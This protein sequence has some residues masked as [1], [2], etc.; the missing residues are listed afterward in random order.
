[1]F[2]EYDFDILK[3]VVSGSPIERDFSIENETFMTDPLGQYA[4]TALSVDY[5]RLALCLAQKMCSVITESKSFP[6]NLFRDALTENFG[7][8][9]VDAKEFSAICEFSENMYKMFH[10]DQKR[11]NELVRESYVN[12]EDVYYTQFFK[13]FRVLAILQAYLDESEEYAAMLSHEKFEQFV[14]GALEMKITKQPIAIATVDSCNDFSDYAEGSIRDRVRETFDSLM[15]FGDQYISMAC[16][17]LT[18]FII[19]TIFYV[20]KNGYQFK[21]CK[22]CGRFFIPFSRSDEIY[23]NNISPQD[24]SR[25]CKKY[26]TEKLWYDRIK[27]DEVAKLSRNIYAAKQMLVKRNP[28]IKDYKEM[29][30]YYKTERE[31]W[32]K[33]VNCGKKSR[34]EYIEWLEQ[35]KKAKTLKQF[36]SNIMGK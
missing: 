36:S 31:K 19:S 18:D 20:F 13:N 4:C 29:F 9:D 7:N 21:R 25:T 28:D 22:N 10:Q 27:N 33:L 32:N 16:S 3:E 35:I 15:L 6:K 12:E 26:G 24:S 17:S 11:Y 30:D 14:N 1:M 2:F 8:I 34:E 23:C 5:E